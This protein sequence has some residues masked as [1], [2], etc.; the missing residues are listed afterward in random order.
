MTR[1]A[2]PY[3]SVRFV[4]VSIR[5]AI[6]EIRMIRS[7]R[8]RP[9]DAPD[10]ELLTDFRTIHWGEYTRRVPDERTEITPCST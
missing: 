10:L 3:S 7:R 9:I 1:G 4:Y 8:N 6:D 5:S 2:Y